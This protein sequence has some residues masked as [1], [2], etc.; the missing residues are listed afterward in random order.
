MARSKKPQ[1]PESQPVFIIRRAIPNDVPTLLKLARMVYFINLPPDN[2]IIGEKVQWSRQSFLLASELDTGAGK[3]SAG[4]RTDPSAGHHGT[5]SA[6]LRAITGKAP[7]FMF[8]LEDAESGTP[9][10]TCQV[11]SR[12]GGPGHPNLSYQLTRKEMFSTDLQVGTTHVVAKLHLDES[13]PTEVGGLILQPSMRS[14]RQR[15]GRFLSY[16]RF[17]FIGLYP[18]LFA[19]RV[20]AEMMAPIS[21]DGQNPF[22]EYF[23]RRFIN[24][25]Y[26]EADRFCQHS[27]EFMLS[28]LPREEIYLTLLPAEA[29]SAV[30]QVSP[31]TVPARRMLEK[32]GFKYHNRIDPFDGGPHLEAKTSDIEIVKKTMRTVLADTIAP[33]ACTMSGYA[34]ILTSDGDFRAVET[35]MSIDKQGRVRMPHD[36]V[37]ALKIEP[38]DSVGVTPIDTLRAATPP[39]SQPAARKGRT[40]SKARS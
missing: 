25:S 39:K 7:L 12:M 8:V 18:E 24:L 5:I 2:T 4:K 13:A 37:E 28:L 11:V 6:G 17:H 38:K 1:I 40:R 3:V 22:W 35:P 20:L 16:I 9:L 34:S 36:A 15:L 10:G 30:G 23:G 21:H 26:P 31:E 29:R 27:K 14:H 33:D 19:D 32:L